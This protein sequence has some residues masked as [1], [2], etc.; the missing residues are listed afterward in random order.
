[1]NTTVYPLLFN[2]LFTNAVFTDLCRGVNHTWKG[3]M[4]GRGSRANNRK[5]MFVHFQAMEASAGPVFSH[6]DHCPKLVLTYFSLW[7]YALL[8]LKFHPWKNLQER[9]RTL[10][11]PRVPCPSPIPILRLWFPV[12][13]HRSKV[14]RLESSNSW[15][16]INLFISLLLQVSHYGV[17]RHTSLFPSGCQQALA[18]CDL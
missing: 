16:K 10:Q 18:L 2:K 12:S 11:D 6:E 5:A 1:M 17:R 15:P 13:P 4:S 3:T 9:P 8:P 14:H 7:E